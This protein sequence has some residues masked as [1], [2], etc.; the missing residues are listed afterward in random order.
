MSVTDD[1]GGGVNETFGVIIQRNTSDPVSTFLDSSTFTIQDNDT[2]ATSYSLTPVSTTVSEG[3]GT[4]TFTV[5]RSGDLPAETI[6]ASTT[7]NQGS[8]NNGDYTGLLN[9]AITFSS[10]QTTRSVTIVIAN[11]ALAES[12]ETFGVVIQRNASDSVDTFLASAL[13]TIQ[14]NDSAS[15][16]YVITPTTTSVSEG[17]GS[18]TFTITRAGLLGAENLFVS[19]T[20][21]HGSVNVGDY[22]GL[23]NQLVTFAAGQVSQTVTLTISNDSVVEGNE[24]F[25]LIVQRNSTDPVTTSLANTTF[26]ILNDDS[27]GWSIA[28]AATSVLEAAGLITFTITRPNGLPAQ[29]VYVSTTQDQGSHNVADYTGLLNQGVTFAEG[30]TTRT[31]TV[32]L[33]NDSVQEDDETFGI[34]VQQSAD[35]P[36]NVRLAGTVFTIENDDAGTPSHQTANPADIF[37]EEGFVGFFGMLAL[38]AYRLHGAEQVGAGVNNGTGDGAASA[39]SIVSDYLRLL[40]AVELP[41]LSPL[42]TND[43]Y[44][45]WGINE[46]VFTNQN[47]AVLVGQAGGALFIAFRGTN[48]F[49]GLPYGTPDTDQWRDVL[50]H[51]DLL[52]PFVAAIEAYI[53]NPANGVSHIYVTGHSLGG[54]MAQ[55]FMI[56]HPS[57]AYTAVT[58][59]N[60]GIPF[61]GDSADTRITNIYVD[62]DVILNTDF[63]SGIRGAQVLVEAPQPNAPAGAVAH[64]QYPYSGVDLHDPDLYWAIAT[65]R[66]SNVTLHQSTHLTAVISGGPGAWYVSLPNGTTYGSDIF[67][68][69]LRSGGQSD[70]LWGL[71][72]DD[73]LYAG[74]GDDFVYGGAGRDWIV[75][76]AGGGSDTYDGGPDADTISYES[77]SLGVTVNLQFMQDQA[78]GVEIG[79]DQLI[80]I[81]NI[82]GGSGPDWIVGDD[83]ANTLTGG[84]GDDT[85]DGGA[86]ADTMIGGDGDDI[87][88]VDNDGDVTTETSALGGSDTVQS[89]VT[90]TLTANIENLILTGAA[91]ITGYGNILNNTLTGN[92]ASNSLYG[93][94]GNDILDGGA[95]EDNMFGGNGDD[96]YYVDNVGDQTIEVSSLGG[97]DTVISSIAR[98]LTANI[99]NLTLTGSAS[100]A[101]YGNALNNTITGNSGANLL[102]GF[103]GG[104]Y[105]NGGAGNDIL[106]GGAGADTMIGGDGDDIY[107]V[108]NAGDVTS[109]T[110]ALGGTDTV[111][112]S[113]TR[114]LNANIENLI[115]TGV[116]AING[117]GNVLNNTITGNSAANQLNGF[118]GND[119][120]DGGAGADNMFGGN[121]DDTYYVDHAGDQTTEVSALGGIDTVIS[122]VSRNLTAHIENLTLTGSANLTASG[123]SLNNTITGNAGNNILYGYDGND[124]LNGGAGADTMFGAAGNDYYVVDNAGDITVEGAAGPA[125]GIDTVESWISRNL[126]AN[127]EN[128]I[129]MGSAANAYG[130]ILDNALTGN[131]AANRLYGFD[132]ADILDGGAGADQMFGG[133]GNDTYIVDN[134]GDVTSETSA[135]GG[136]DTVISSVTRNLTAN[137][138]NLTL[139]GGA[140]INGAGNALNNIV[141]GNDGANT[142]YGLDGDDR[143]DGG[144]GADTLQG[145]LH[146]D[147]YVFSTAIGGGN[148][149]AIIG[150][151]VADDTIE[152]SNA[153]YTGLSTGALDANAFV[154]GAAAADAD[155]RII[156]NSATGQ[157]FFDADG[158]GAGA[159]ILFATLAPGLALTSA[160]FIVGGP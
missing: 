13:F 44:G 97:V 160:D 73:F 139:T 2:V 22:V 36:V 21:D 53:D 87:Y 77:T 43:A 37:A 34:I 18:I 29:T 24:T 20:Q 103:E 111:Q 131:A 116:A 105:L 112:S 92:S 115:L 14:D 4:I 107:I 80:G 55:Q 54:A 102:Y 113:V 51:Y 63:F 138:E 119:I 76:G 101:G 88:I 95:G 25:G 110:S 81:E 129:L 132:G 59:A 62:G 100:I 118:D 93:F 106:D 109:E 78:S 47:A 150:F 64:I 91:A 158:T 128:L 17:A 123:N 117:F 74:D 49:T 58:F 3:V 90:R 66:S 134:A 126:N 124:I 61:T 46:G 157:L 10:G 98:N 8:S 40:T 69:F 5:T 23:L 71:G 45:T 130:N 108:D 141:I 127:F 26:T 99:E 65:L 1:S 70:T 89:S 75:G 12:D 151:N 156:Y 38:A 31:V 27:A 142:L 149:D 85:L 11:D 153:V 120:L 152:L 133:N 83:G 16:S 146:A 35:D 68:D 140:N 56:D 7:T 155:D 104:D 154:I 143:L 145:G 72:G 121:G 50:A 15:T 84:G 137:L 48:D 79:V 96:T 122:S 28:P 41:S 33:N 57:A 147:T 148:V 135:L 6:Y 82:V 144:L 125:G 19:T 86:G 39:Y 136:I 60:P 52:R 42:N 114:T 67:N 159:A 94:D 30:Q 9:Q 32:V